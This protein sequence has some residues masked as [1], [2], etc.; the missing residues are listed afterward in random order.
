[1]ENRRRPRIA[2]NAARFWAG[3][4]AREIVRT[5]LPDLEPYFEFEISDAPQVV[6]YGP[7]P[8][9][10]PAGRYTKVFIGCENVFPIM[11]ECDWAFGVLNDHLVAH[12]KYMRIRR[13]G[14]HWEVVQKEK[15]WREVLRAKTRFCAFVYSHPVYY[16]EAFFR[17]LSRYKRV[18][19]PGQSM[20]NMASFD[21]VPG[22]PDW[23]SKVE[24]LRQYKFVVAFENSS[25]AGYHSEK[26]VHA[27]KADCL[28][29]Y[30][31]DPEYGRTYNANRVVNAMDYLPAPRRF[32]PRL[33]ESLHSLE[34]DGRSTLR[35][36]ATRRLNALAGE[37]EQ[38]TWALAGF[39]ALI[40]KIIQIDRDDD[41]YVRYLRE[42]FL[43]GNE[44]PD[45][46]PWI[47]RWKEIFEDAQKAS[48]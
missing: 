42:P 4:T 28:P 22:T 39:D 31:G 47:A 23:D 17:A 38:R 16:R 37:I 43:I 45:R 48:A 44:L 41:L 13:W 7:Y 40:A 11:R 5:I 36:R 25:R 1:L 46:T 27:V 33:P 12:E 9:E 18:D 20:N 29:V 24:F 2:I 14:D 15:N 6:L 19:S 30:W 8:G 10:M 34:H 21:P 32:L 26:V 35:V 3:V